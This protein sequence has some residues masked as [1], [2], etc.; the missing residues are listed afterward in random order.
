MTQNFPNKV[1]EQVR[2][3]VGAMG[4][5]GEANFDVAGGIGESASQAP[6]GTAGDAAMWRGDGTGPTFSTTTMH[7]GTYD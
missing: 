7:D 4:V 5:S 1:L 6:S 3:K 2:S